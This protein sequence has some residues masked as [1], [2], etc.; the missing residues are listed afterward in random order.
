MPRL[1]IIWEYVEDAHAA[2]RLLR[3]F[4]MILRQTSMRT[5]FDKDAKSGND[6]REV[7]HEEINRVDP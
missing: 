5:A 6:G 4:E 1:P 3:A 2:E 7:S